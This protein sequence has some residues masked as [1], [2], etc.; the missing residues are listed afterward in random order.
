MGDGVMH[1]S[2][3][4]LEWFRGGYKVYCVRNQQYT[5]VLNHFEVSIRDGASICFTIAAPSLNL[6]K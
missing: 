4:G 2:M 5:L 3:V 1:F 6:E